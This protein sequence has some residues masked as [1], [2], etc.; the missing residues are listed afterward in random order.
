MSKHRRTPRW[1]V[2][3]VE[4]ILMTRHNQKDCCD[5]CP[6]RKSPKHLKAPTINIF[7][8]T[9]DQSTVCDVKGE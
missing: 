3:G 6:D 4:V 8:F 5:Y 9:V 2:G 7:I 1:K